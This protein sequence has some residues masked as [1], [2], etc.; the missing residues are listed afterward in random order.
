MQNLKNNTEKPE[1]SDAWC[2]I[3]LLGLQNKRMFAALIT[4]LVLWAATIGGFVWYLYQ[5]DF[6]T[7]AYT[8][9]GEGMNVI[10]DSNEV[11]DYGANTE[12]TQTNP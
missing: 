2:M 3:E 4:V 11:T 7:C 9:D 6:E 12:S 5:Y 8:Q 10:G 1:R